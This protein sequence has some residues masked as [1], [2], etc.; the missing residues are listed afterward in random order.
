MAAMSPVKK[1]K[2]RVRVPSSTQSKVME[3]DFAPATTPKG[4]STPSSKPAVS[5]KDRAAYIAPASPLAVA[6]KDN[7]SV[8]AVHEDDVDDEPDESHNDDW[9][10]EDHNEGSSD[11][12]YDEEAEEGYEDEADKD[13]W[14]HLVYTPSQSGVDSQNGSTKVRKF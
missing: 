10:D 6:S 5:V 7:K 12:D 9:A 11:K 8:G 14:T 4:T 1:G 3:S 13:G 2:E